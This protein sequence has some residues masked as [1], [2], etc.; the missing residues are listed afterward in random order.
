MDII[1]DYLNLFV[2]DERQFLT[3][4]IVL[5]AWVGLAALGRVF[6]KNCTDQVILP[7][8]GWAI[9]ANTLTLVGIFT[10]IGFWL[11]F[12]LLTVTATITFLYSIITNAK[13]FPKTFWQTILLVS[14]LLALTAAMDASQWDEFSH[15]LPIQRFLIETNGFP[16]NQ[17][18]S[19]GTPLY[20]GYPNNWPFLAMIPSMAAGRMLEMSGGIFN[21]LLLIII[22]V[23]AVDTFYKFAKIKKPNGYS[24]G[25]A[26][27]PI[28]A[29]TI[30]NPTFIQKIILT[31]YAD[32]ATLACSGIG[33]FLCWRLSDS[34]AAKNSAETKA[35]A[36]Q[37]GIAMTL[38]V[39]VKQSNLV[40]FFLLVFAL[41]MVVIIDPLISKEKLFRLLPVILLP[42]LIMYICW[43]YH[44]TEA[45]GKDAV[46]H[47][48]KPFS[49]WNWDVVHL[50]LKQALVVA[51]KKIAFFG[52]MTIA[53][54]FVI[55]QFYSKWGSYQRLTFILVILFLGHNAFLLFTYLASF[56]P[57]QA[58]TVVSYWRYNTHVGATAILFLFSTLG[59]YLHSLPL[60]KIK[61]LPLSK[62]AVTL[63]ILL[64]L[65]FAPKLRFDLESPKPHFN[66]V[67]HELSKTLKPND[68]VYILDP[69]G[70]AES[71]VITRYRIKRNISFQWGW[72]K[73]TSFEKLKNF[74]A[75]VP[76]RGYLLVHSSNPAIKRILPLI[77]YNSSY[78][79]QKMGS[80]WMIRKSWQFPDDHKPVS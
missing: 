47:S 73:D 4:S 10:E 58:A 31:N 32:I 2:G 19:V 39:N 68:K 52:L 11:V 36:F 80:K 37:F 24:W 66:L 16:S 46:E 59:F 38:L 77:K 21:L 18:P 27:F 22:G 65:I 45:L 51:F 5:I 74:V 3:L 40:L 17:N 50:I 48:F 14:P 60:R 23:I 1:I 7:M 71:V 9:F 76:H 41:I 57:V 54:I 70:T 44:V 78:L 28:L 12:I 20:S 62:I 63:A 6:F 43:R 8:L 56:G 64:P 15:W 25:L 79:F 13:I 69:L 42:P 53:T 72:H 30:L 34:L 49:E 26:A 33:A 67:A 55:L 29:I 35:I 75:S 61:T